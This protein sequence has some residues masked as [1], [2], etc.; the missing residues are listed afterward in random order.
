MEQKLRKII[1]LPGYDYSENGVYF[2]TFCVKDNRPL[3]TDIRVG[4]TI[5]RLPEICLTDKGLIVEKAIQNIP[6]VYPGVYIDQYVIMPN[7]VHM[8]IRIDRS[9]SRP[10]VGPA[11]LPGL[12]RMIAQLKGFVTKQIGET[13][14]QGKYYDH[15]IRDEQDYMTRW[16]YIENNPANWLLKQDE[17]YSI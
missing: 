10:M 6:S 14:W 15:I 12:S 1:R 8:L 13:I 2:V 5:G 11:R 3:L 9:Y 7:H 17:Y 16:R 4:P